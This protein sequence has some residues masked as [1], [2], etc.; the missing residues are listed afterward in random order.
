MQL[1]ELRIPPVRAYTVGF[2]AALAWWPP[3]AVVDAVTKRFTAPPKPGPVVWSVGA[4]AFAKT[5][6]SPY[7]P[8]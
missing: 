4:A 7:Y 5:L 3:P 1:A 6:A 2:P 8:H